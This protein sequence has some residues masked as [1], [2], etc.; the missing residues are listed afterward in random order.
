MK[1]RSTYQP[2]VLALLA[3]FTL[4]GLFYL[5]YLWVHNRTI[6][7]FSAQQTMLARQAADGLQAYFADYGRALD[8][9]SQQPG[10]QRLDR[11]SVV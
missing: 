9:L 8:Y 5:P 3:T 11:K 2:I 10:I 1:P 7:A 6:E 4:A